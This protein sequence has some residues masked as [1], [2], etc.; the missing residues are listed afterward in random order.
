MGCNVIE[1]RCRG[2]ARLSFQPKAAY[3][4]ERCRGVVR[5]NLL[6]KAASLEGQCQVAGH[7]E[8]ECQGFVHLKILPKAAHFEG[9][10]Q[11][12]LFGFLPRKTDC[13]ALSVW[14]FGLVLG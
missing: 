5:L 2:V 13:N 8:G 1:E 3:L 9:R 6:P 14:G 11:T 4:E 12:S 7:P 10:C